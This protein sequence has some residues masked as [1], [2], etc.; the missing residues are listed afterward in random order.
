M[1]FVASLERKTLEIMRQFKN[2]GIIEL[3]L[4]NKYNGLYS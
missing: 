2:R 1:M 4:S 3:T